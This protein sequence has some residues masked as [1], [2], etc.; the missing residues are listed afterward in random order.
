MYALLGILRAVR[1]RA[2]RVRRIRIQ[3]QRSA[4]ARCLRPLG[5]GG[6]GQTFGLAKA[7]LPSVKW[8][9]W[10][11]GLSDWL[12]CDVWEYRYPHIL[13]AYPHVFATQLLPL[14]TMSSADDR[15]VRIDT[16]RH[17]LNLYPFS[18]GIFREILQNSEDARASKQVQSVRHTFFRHAEAA[19]PRFFS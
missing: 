7:T 5:M 10:L 3:R 14:P 8:R 9:P 6:C 17:V 15:D 1:H 19:V 18:I 12:G 11:P 2:S 4:T 13:R 16:I